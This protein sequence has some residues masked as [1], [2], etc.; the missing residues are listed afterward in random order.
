MVELK[1]PNIKFREY[2]NF[3]SKYC[4]Q[5][6]LT[7]ILKGSLADNSACEYS[8]ID[9]IVFGKLKE[10]NIY[11]IIYDYNNPLIINISTNP[12]GMLIITYENGICIDLDIRKTIIEEDII[13]KNK[14]L[15]NNG[16]NLSQSIIRYGL[17]IS[18]Y[19]NNYQHELFEIFKLII[20][21]TNK[22]LSNKGTVAN[23]FLI[24]IKEKCKS[25]FGIDELG[26]NNNYKHDIQL[27]YKHLL[28]K[29]D[30]DKTKLK[31]FDILLE[32]L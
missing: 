9:L 6:N 31:Y 22:Y 12:K 7:L 20:K 1:Y 3:I 15:V 16:I 8:D 18:D 32:L 17:D 27:I 5:S 2:I 4:E 30:I 14:I 26:F 10:D 28:L 24:E 25:Y 11:E 23:E 13:Q 21:G 29:N 19:S